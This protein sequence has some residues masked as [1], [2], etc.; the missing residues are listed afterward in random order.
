MSDFHMITKTCLSVHETGCFH[1]LGLQAELPQEQIAAAVLSPKAVKKSIFVD[2]DEPYTRKQ[3]QKA[4]LKRSDIFLVT[5]GPGEGI[6]AVKVPGHCEFQWAEYERIDWDAVLAGKHGASS[7]C[8]RKGLSRKAQLAYYTHRHVCKHPNSILSY[9]IPKTVILDTWSVW[10][11][12]AGTTN[13]EG[14]ADLVVSMGSPAI[15]SGTLNRRWRLDQSLIEAKRLMQCVNYNGSQCDGD[16]FPIWILKG[17]TVNKGAGIF[18]IHF[19]EEL[20]DICWSEPQIREWVLQQYITVPLLLRK[21]KFHIRAYVVAVSAIKVYFCQECLALCSGTKYKNCDTKDLFSHITNTAY[22]DLD[23][24][25]SE[26][27]CIFVWNEQSIVPILL[28]DNTCENEEDACAKVR[29]VVRDMESIVAELFNAYK[30]EFGVF[31]PIEGCFEHYGLDFLVDDNW[32]VYLLEVN[33]GPDFKQTGTRLQDVVG[34]LMLATI[35]AVFEISNRKE[36]GTL[37]LVYENETR[38]AKVKSGINIMLT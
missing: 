26:E 6:D 9:C 27:N 22:Q 38:G 33:P 3:V 20:V 37:K 14:F 2:I 34:N 23:P 25:F 30:S 29:N 19:Y 21:R 7:Y 15:T 11:D 8:I 31:A 28:R 13:H 1:V 32:N 12:N 4:F 36:I 24:G 16:P 10:D 35:D 5:M 17:S 18:L